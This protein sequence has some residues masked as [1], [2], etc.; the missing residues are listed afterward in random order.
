MERIYCGNDLNSAC[1]LLDEN[2]M[3]YDLDSGD[4]IMTDEP[5]AVAELLE[6]HGLQCHIV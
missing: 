1:N 4:R 5:D 3:V 6:K 2:E